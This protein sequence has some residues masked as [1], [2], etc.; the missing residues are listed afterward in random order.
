MVDVNV[1]LVQKCGAWRRMRRAVRFRLRKTHIHTST[2]SRKTR[3]NDRTQKPLRSQEVAVRVQEGI[4]AH[5]V[6]KFEGHSISR[7]LIRGASRSRAKPYATASGCQVKRLY[8]S[9]EVGE[10]RDACVHSIEGHGSAEQE[11]SAVG[12]PTSGSPATL[13]DKSAFQGEGEG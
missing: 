10:G 5:I 6:P 12:L 8:R 1:R 3:Q 11:T 7:R 2:R 9:I 4:V 13:R